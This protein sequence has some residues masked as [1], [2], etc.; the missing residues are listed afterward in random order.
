M[1]MTSSEILPILEDMLRCKRSAEGD[2]I[3]ECI[4]K[5]FG[6]SKDI[7]RYTVDED[8][9][10]VTNQTNKE[11]VFGSFKQF[12]WNRLRLDSVCDVYK[13]QYER[14]MELNCGI[15]Y[16]ETNIVRDYDE[17]LESC[18]DFMRS[19]WNVNTN[20]KEQGGLRLL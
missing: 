3:D 9:I 7:W 11:S 18:H 5:P 1:K 6:G 12:L 17:R 4:Y 16:V 20:G 10:I 2:W 8:K 13:Q 15:P 19:I 14:W